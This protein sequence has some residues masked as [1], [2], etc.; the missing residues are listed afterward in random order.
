MGVS[1]LNALYVQATQNSGPK[2]MMSSMVQIIPKDPVTFKTD[3]FE[4]GRHAFPVFAAL[5]RHSDQV[6]HRF[7][8]LW[9]LK[10]VVQRRL[11]LL[12]RFL[13]VP[14]PISRVLPGK[15][16]SI[17]SLNFYVGL[18]SPGGYAQAR[19]TCFFKNL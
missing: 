15:S 18:R 14:L 1:I 12:L 2:N 16:P 8:R 4:R 7:E 13:A 6:S 17:N 11:N 5:G 10:K 3:G 9:L 19:P